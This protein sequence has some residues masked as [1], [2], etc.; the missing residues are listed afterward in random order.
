MKIW[1][2]SEERARLLVLGFHRNH[3]FLLGRRTKGK[4][5]CRRMERS[6]DTAL[7]QLQLAAR[8]PNCSLNSL[9]PRLLGCATGL[10]AAEEPAAAGRNAR[11]LQPQADAEDRQ[12]HGGRHDRQ[13]R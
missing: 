5:V 11:L 2:R 4:R 1:L 9:I 7:C 3:T 12:R 8:F 13:E 10:E 6:L